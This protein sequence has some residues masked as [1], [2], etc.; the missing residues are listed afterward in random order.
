MDSALTG[1]EG[2]RVVS[3][4]RAAAADVPGV[5]AVGDPFAGKGGALSKDT[6]IGFFE[7][8]FDKPAR[9]LDEKVIDQIQ[10]PL[11]DDAMQEL[12][13]R[14]DLDKK[15]PAEVAKEYLSETGLVK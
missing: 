1:T 6:K 14:V 5:I 3:A 7:A 13:A 2:H 8:Q 12:D 9:E 11:T 10:K 4:A 15:T